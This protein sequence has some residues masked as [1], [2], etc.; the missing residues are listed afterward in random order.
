MRSVQ[1]FISSDN[2]FRVH[3]EQAEL[4]KQLKIES[5]GFIS[6]YLDELVVSGF[7]DRD[8]TW[9]IKT[10]HVSKL[11]QY[12]LSDNYLRFYLRYIQ[13][14]LQK[15]KQGQFKHHS[16]TALTGWTAIMGLQ[17][18]NLVLNNRHEIKKRLGIYPDELSMIILIFRGRQHVR[19]VVKLLI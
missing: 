12:R 7:L 8:Y 18:E 5:G 13:P 9:Q 3:W 2:L 11:S 10:A 1:A 16:L 4:F 6:S 19:K 14:N 17:I 15:I